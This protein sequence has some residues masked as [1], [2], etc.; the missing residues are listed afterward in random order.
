[1]EK[2]AAGMVEAW[3]GAVRDMQGILVTDHASME[4]A[5]AAM[6]RLTEELGRT[7]E[8]LTQIRRRLAGLEGNMDDLREQGTAFQVRLDAQAGVL[9]E[10]HSTTEVQAARLLDIVAVVKKFG[11]SLGD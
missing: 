2:L 5:A 10:L 7:N 9:R 8:E 6:Q 4:V 3:N 11:E 1:M